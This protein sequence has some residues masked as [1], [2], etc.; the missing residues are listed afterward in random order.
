MLQ[1]AYHPVHLATSA[2]NLVMPSQAV[3]IPPLDHLRQYCSKH[4]VKLE[5]LFQ[6]GWAIILSLYYDTPVF[7]FSGVNEREAA[8][9]TVLLHYVQ[10]LG[11]HNTVVNTLRSVNSEN[12]S[13]D[14][15]LYHRE[16]EQGASQLP[17]VWS[18]LC[19]VPSDVRWHS[20]AKGVIDGRNVRFLPLA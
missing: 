9:Q 5:S 18:R 8:A 6:L 16:I 2:V 7:V 11:K 12:P 14:P 17:K 15:V 19:F 4:D 13:K 20:N 3:Q 1:L 10:D